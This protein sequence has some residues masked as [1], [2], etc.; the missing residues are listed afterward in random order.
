MSTV[1]V[2]KDF[3][4]NLLV[5]LQAFNQRVLNNQDYP[6]STLG[7]AEWLEFEVLGG[8]KDDNY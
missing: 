2:D 7:L 8:N 4:V 5:V 6:Y 1:N 3:V